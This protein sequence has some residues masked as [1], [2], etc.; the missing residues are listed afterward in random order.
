MSGLSTAKVN[1]QTSG[2]KFSPKKFF[3]FL[4]QWFIRNKLY[5]L[6]FFIPVVIMFTGYALFK[7]FPFGQESVLVLDLNG[8]YVYYFEA[9]RDAFWGDGSMLYNWSRN[10][11]GGYIG[12]I[13]YYLA[14]PFTLI[15]ML[16]PRTML[17]ESL[18]IMILAKVGTASVTFSYYLQKSKG[19][20]PLQSIVFS[21][22]YALCAYGVIQAMDPM[23]LDGVIL[24]PLIILGVEYLIDDGRKL[25]YIIPLAIMFISNFYIGYIVGIFTFIYFVFYLFTG[26]DDVNKKTAAYDKLKI[27]GRFALSTVVSLMC[28][29][30][31]LLSVYNALQLGKFDFSQPDFSFATQ[32]NPLDFF[33][34]LLPGQYDT[35]NVEGLPEIYCGVLTLIMLPLFYMNKEVALRKKIGYTAVLAVLFTSMFIRPIDMVWHGFQMPNWLPFRYSF[36]FSFVLVIMGA[37]AF[38][39]FSG[40]KLSG[41]VGSVVGVLGFVALVACRKIDHLSKTDLLLAAGYVVVYGVIVIIARHKEKFFAVA[42][43]IAIL[44]LSSGELVYNCYNTYKDEDKDLIY[45]ARTTWYNYINNGREVT[46]QLYNYD[47]SFYRA[48][49]TFHRTVNDNSAF[50]LRGLS[51]SSS[52]MNAKVLTFLEA[53]G[54]STSTYFSRYDGNTPITDSLLGIKYAMD[55]NLVGSSDAKRLVNETY[56]PVFAYNYVNEDGKDTVIDVYQNPNAL[57]IGYMADENVTYIDS[58]GNDNT[59]NSQNIF[60]ST[61]SGNT[62][63]DLNQGT[64]D[65]FHEYFKPI[66]V[67]PNTFELNNVT[68][69]PYGEDQTMYTAAA[70][71]DPTVNMHI[72]APSDQTIYMFFKTEYQKSV[73]L[74][75]STEKDA[76]GNY[77]NHKFVGAYFENHDYHTVNLGKFEPGQEFELRMTVANEYTI[78]KNFFFYTFDQDL[79]QQDIDKV[80]QNQWNLTEAGGRHLEGTIT[81]EK[82]QVMMT[83]IPYEPGWTVKVDGKKVEPICI[84]KALLGVKLEPGEHTVEMTYTPPG[85][86]P[87]LGAMV[88]GIICIVFIYRYD[89]KNNKVLIARYRAK[90]TGQSVQNKTVK[91]TAETKTEE[92][93]TPAAENKEPEQQKDIQ[94]KAQEILENNNSQAVNNQTAP[95]NN[96]KK[97]KKK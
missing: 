38:K 82:G 25:N 7:V 33:P 63:I 23:W 60:M 96:K 72:K 58:L 39:K 36:T 5:F 40:V 19:M 53:L 10:L 21:T 57:S 41:V 18:L 27:F 51:H 20:K 88:L 30:F 54:Y 84:V 66:D 68:T 80:K 4:G 45:S 37:T 79:F 9:L 2:K 47:P 70:E 15:V 28:A 89:K 17:L 48:E 75:L 34:Q 14:S 52:V 69:S 50:G 77:I 29:A 46:Q 1:P 42:A 85:F 61:I 44:A 81:A 12:I 26:K 78:V 71:G 32:F 6:A 90:T 65:S 49:K 67:D 97:N 93:E 62:V 76:D 24:L 35:V 59:F 43:P 13:A 11:S 91:N 92:K 22:L 87:G 55:K 74:W 64:F 86:V 95:K 83:S 73:N 8:Q 94:E 56:N 16:L 31:M 3:P